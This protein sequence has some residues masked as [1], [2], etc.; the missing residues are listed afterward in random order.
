MKRILQLFRASRLERDLTVEMQAHLEEKIDEMI[1]EGMRPEEARTLAQRQ[2]GNRAQLVEAC[3]DRWTFV[4]LVEIAQDLRYA[5]RVLRKSPGFTAAAVLSL[6]LGIGANTIVFSAVNHVL[7]NP[8]PYARPDRLFAIW[9]RSP[10]RGPEP[11]HV[12]AADF[13]DWQTQ[14]HA[15]ESMAAYANWP[16][17]LTGVD[18]PR[19]LETQLV[20][21]SLFSTLGV[22]A[23]LGRTFLPGEDLEK[24]PPVVVISHGLWRAMGES[25]GIVGSKVILNGSPATVV[26]VMPSGF[27]FPSR[28]IDAWVPLSL[29]AQNRANREG[30]WLAVIGRLRPNASRADA[31]AEMD[32]IFEPPG[33]RV[34][35][36]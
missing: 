29:N 16:M 32:V 2:F 27:A 25:A 33:S 11:M 17:N 24:S 19:R 36:D 35:G 26:G 14:S 12:S 5:A 7:L 1:D 3:R 6:A 9:S 10:V 23:Q 31:A 15:L 4:S 13:Y 30:R 20:S 18:E 8:L 34:P 21:A 28:E 22:P